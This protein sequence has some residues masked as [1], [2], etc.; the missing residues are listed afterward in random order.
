MNTKRLSTYEEQISEHL[1]QLRNAGLDVE[2]LEIGSERFIPC[3]NLKG[4]RE[5]S[6]AYKTQERQ[7][8]NGNI[9]LITWYRSAD[10]V[11]DTIKTQSPNL[12][13]C[14]KHK[15]FVKNIPASPSDKINTKINDAVAKKAYGIWMNASDV[16]T[17]D[18]LNRKR[19]CSYG[20]KFKETSE[21]GRAAIVPMKN[22]A[23][24]IMNVQFLNANGKKIVLGDDSSDQSNYLGLF[25]VIGEPKNNEN[26]G[27]AESYVTAA[28]CYE[29]SGIPCICAFSAWNLS[30]VGKIFR[31]RYPGSRILF[32]ADNDRHSKAAGR[33]NIG[34]EQAEKAASEVKFNAYVV[35]PDFESVPPAKDASDWND[36]LIHRGFE[37]A[38]EQ[39]LRKV[40]L[41]PGAQAA[42][43]STSPVQ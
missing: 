19:V 43:S 26:I 34:L 18:Y 32:F 14:S 12:D 30:F 28:T 31:T 36:L 29:L 42:I 21:Y 16:G 8:N 33:D 37:F 40:K 6:L 4:G 5:K 9:G 24:R 41:L 2:N 35:E 3:Y 27:I 11:T 17:S 15:P 25:H 22:E 23:D 39:I 1:T 20:L 13:D 10:G 7:L 38:E